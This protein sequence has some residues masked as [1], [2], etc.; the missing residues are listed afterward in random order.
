MINILL[1]LGAKCSHG[2]KSL[3]Q[4]LEL[5]NIL[6]FHPILC[7][8]YAGPFDVTCKHCGVVSTHL[9]SDRPSFLPKIL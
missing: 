6:V 2:Y 7:I 5:L 8:I 9:P 1:F 4:F 3:L